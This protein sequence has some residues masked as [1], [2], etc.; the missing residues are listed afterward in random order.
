MASATPDTVTTDGVRAALRCL[1][2]RGPL[3]HCITNVVVAGFTANVLLAVGAS[4]AMV[5][6][7]DEA[8]GFARVA[9]GLLI[10]LGTLSGRRIAAMHVAADA[11]TGLTPWVL[12]PVGAG[13]LPVRTSLAREL[14]E[15][16]PTVLRGNASEV[17]GVAAQHG[18]PAGQDR[19]GRG[20]DSGTSSDTA[21]DAAV[22]LA[23]RHGCVVAVSGAT[24]VITDGQRLVLVL[25]GSPLMTAVT[26][27]GCALGAL[28]AAMLPVTGSPLVAATAATALLDAAGT[29]AAAGDPGPGTFAV[30]LLDELGTLDADT[31]LATVSV[32]TAAAGAP[33]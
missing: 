4:P 21:V 2:Q 5:D 11:A 8:A 7:E 10:N 27:V 28:V 9:D 33:R 15:R 22:S 30:R 19:R 12:D 31:V 1:R 25:G 29:R 17:L 16:R 14:I 3:V 26:G 18:Q 24:D 23:G 32:E 13:A 6:D 20:V